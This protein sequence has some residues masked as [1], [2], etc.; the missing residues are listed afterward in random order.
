MAFCCCCVPVLA[1]VPTFTDSWLLQTSLILLVS[2]RRPPCFFW[3]FCCSWLSAVVG[4]NALA[5][6]HTAQASPLMLASLQLLVWCPSLLT[7]ILDTSD[8]QSIITMGIWRSE[9]RILD[10]QIK[11]LVY[12]PIIGYV[13]KVSVWLWL[14]VVNPKLPLFLFFN[15]SFSLSNPGLSC[16]LPT[17]LTVDY[18]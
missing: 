4:V 18:F 11:A 7:Q 3:R 15:R 14:G 2:P 9:Y 1:G 16:R 8:Y 5:E 12:H 10:Q 6:V 17:F 13:L